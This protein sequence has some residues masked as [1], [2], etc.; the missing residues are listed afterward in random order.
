MCIVAHPDDECFAFGGA[1]ALAAQQGIETYVICLTDG[2][3]ATNRGDSCS[4]ED[5]G[6]M[7]REEFAASCRVLGVSRYELLDYQD[8]QLEFA[9][10]SKAAGR[11]VA[12][13]REYKPD[14]MV[15]FGLDG[16]LNTHPDHTMVASLTSA[17]FH[18]AGLEKRYKGLGPV[19]LAKRL[20]MLSTDFFMDGRPEPAP[21]PWTVKLDVRAAMEQRQEAF[22][23]HASQA[24]LMERT[25]AMFEEHGAFEYYTLVAERGCAAATAGESL[26]AG[27]EG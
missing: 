23:Q 17:A 11:L 6:R 12:K 22:R 3:A 27:L 16:G 5:L 25:R 1:L 18:W 8:A 14:V 19:H 10:F 2:Q 9:D 24:P 7:R 21:L 13:V 15:T 4:S 20:Y 26:F